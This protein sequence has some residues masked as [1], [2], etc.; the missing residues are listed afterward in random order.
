MPR[1]DQHPPAS[2]RTQQVA[3]YLRDYITSRHLRAGARLPGEAEIS[4]ELGISRPSVREASAALSAIGLISVGNG[5]RPCVGTLNA[6]RSDA[7]KDRQGLGGGVLRGVL[8]AALMTDQADLRQ[9]MELRRG[10]EIEMAALAAR[11][12]SPDQLDQLA[13]TLQAM[14]ATLQDR[15]RYAEADLHFHI[16]LGQATGNPLYT[17]LVTETQQAVL[18]SLAIALR[19]SAGPAE[20]DRVQHLHRAVLDAVIAGDP[21]AARRAMAKHFDDADRALHRLANTEEN[22]DA[23]RR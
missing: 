10:L 11:R 4:R 9:V 17:L 12:R 14:A 23:A 16:L 6:G 13:A 21:A 20:L 2:P 5:R 18:S 19:R 7:G 1:Q 22:D 3:D 8:E 15:A